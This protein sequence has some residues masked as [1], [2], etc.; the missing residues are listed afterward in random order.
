MGLQ[1]VDTTEHGHTYSKW[2]A[3]SRD[4]T[5]LPAVDGL[6]AAPPG[7]SETEVLINASV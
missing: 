2:S 4:R 1:R 7:K 3:P 6:S 5:V